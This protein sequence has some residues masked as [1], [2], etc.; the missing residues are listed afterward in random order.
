MEEF[1]KR[2]LNKCAHCS[3][4]VTKATFTVD[5]KLYFVCKVHW[6]LI[7]AMSKKLAKIGVAF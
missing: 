2:K 5:G 1:Q 3:N 4:D 7:E 6:F